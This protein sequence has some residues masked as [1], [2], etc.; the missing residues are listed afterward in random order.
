MSTSVNHNRKCSHPPF[1]TY[2][3]IT[4]EIRMPGGQGLEFLELGKGGAGLGFEGRN[5][6]CEVGPKAERDE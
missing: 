5:R 6:G 2:Q 3:E 1:A 4:P